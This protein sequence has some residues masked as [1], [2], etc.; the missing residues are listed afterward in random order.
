[1]AL[2]ALAEG[3]G[4]PGGTR[5]D[6]GGDE[7]PGRPGREPRAPRPA[8]DGALDDRAARVP[9]GRRVP[10][11]HGPHVPRRRL[12]QRP[13]G[14]GH[15]HRAGE[16]GDRDALEPGGDEAN[17]VGRVALAERH[18]RRARRAAER[19]LQPARVPGAH[20]VPGD[21]VQPPGPDDRRA[22]RRGRAPVGAREGVPG[23]VHG[24]DHAAGVEEAPGVRARGE[25]A[26]GR[27]GA[28]Q[29]APHLP[30][31][32]P[33]VLPEPAPEELRQL[34][35]RRG[36]GPARGA[37]RLQPRE[38]REEGR[39][40]RRVVREAGVAGGPHVPLLGV[41]VGPRVARQ[42]RDDAGHVVE[43]PRAHRPVEV[44]HEAVDLAVL[45]VDLVDARRQV[46][47][48]L[49][50]HVPPR[51]APGRPA[52]PSLLCH[53]RRGTASRRARPARAV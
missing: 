15:P 50:R 45:G 24:A 33:D 8:A 17:R 1:V 10:V 37:D 19:G 18:H 2:A 30:V 35:H 11:V 53:I 43:P 26:P 13:A 6:Q 5:P 27:S 20:L 22:E 25:R 16:V 7:L 32:P 34:H 3:E 12:A 52:R 42:R 23:E 36:L 39:V 40:L 44:V 31:H 41:E 49:D 4:E 29:G 46:R 47:R 38:L 9:V 51:R 48:P 14:D 28:P 21:V